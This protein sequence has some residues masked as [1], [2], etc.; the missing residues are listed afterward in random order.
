MNAS[1]VRTLAV[2]CCCCGVGRGPGSSCEAENALLPWLLSYPVAQRPLL[3]RRLSTSSVA[4]SVRVRCG[5]DRV[6]LVEA[7]MEEGERKG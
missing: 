4:L 1:C 3:V 7:E 2:G 6:A 5:A